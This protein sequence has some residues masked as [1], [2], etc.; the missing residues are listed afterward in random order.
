MFKGISICGVWDIVSVGGG[1]SRV[2][3]GGT[4]VILCGIGDMSGEVFT[5]V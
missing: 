5:A 2:V 4:I 3:G 1:S